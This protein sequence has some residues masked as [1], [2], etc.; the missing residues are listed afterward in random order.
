MQVNY[1]PSTVFTIGEEGGYTADPRDS[2]NWSS[3]QTG[4]G[5]LIGSNMGCGA[6]A[7]IAYMAQTQPGFTV[8]PAWMQALPRAVYDG[9]ARGSY[10]AP[11]Q[12]DQLPAGLD[13]A[14]FDFGWNTGIGSAARRL[15]W[16]IGA[17]QDGQIGPQSLARLSACPLAPIA[18]ALAASEART[19]QAA[20]GVTVDGEVGPQTLGALAAVPDA[21]IRPVV[22]L[23]GLGEAQ[24]AYYRSL[25]NFPIYGAGWLA[26]T[27]R[28][29]AT[30]LQLAQGTRAG[31]KAI[32]L[33]DRAP[34]VP[35]EPDGTRWHPFEPSLPIAIQAARLAA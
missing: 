33:T 18:A 10:W 23:L 25:A 35:D 4:I 1:T 14:C 29:I 24:T 9:M 22:L 11:L 6:P 19:L 21:A 32:P 34:R 8:T 3:G 31:A 27:G 30:G 15:Q 2:G 5:T 28:R 20:L 26:R 12:G 7:T 16:L 13:L 17:E